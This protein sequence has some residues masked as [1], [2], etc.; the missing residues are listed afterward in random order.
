MELVDWG[1]TEIMEFLDAGIVALF[2][3]RDLVGQAS[4]PVASNRHRC[5]NRPRVRCAGQRIS[6]CFGRPKRA[7]GI[8]CDR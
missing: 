7:T 6:G 5:A 2:K 4:E 1:L 3:R 8:A